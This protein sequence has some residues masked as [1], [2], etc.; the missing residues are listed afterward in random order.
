MADTVNRIVPPAV[1]LGPGRPVGGDQER[2]RPQRRP[3][4]TAQEPAP[5]EP[6]AVDDNPE[7]GRNLDIK[8]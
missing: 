2:R 4:E 6:D 8:A 3:N 7:K 1:P 5:A